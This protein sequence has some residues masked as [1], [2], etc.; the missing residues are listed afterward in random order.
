VPWMHY[1]G[2]ECLAEDDTIMPQ[3]SLNRVADYL[4]K[5]TSRHLSESMSDRELLER[6]VIHREE[7]A[8]AAIVGRH[9]PMVN[10]VCRRLLK[11]QA[12]ADDA[13][14]ATFLILLRKAGSIAKRE[15][16]ASWLHGVAHRVSNRAHKLNRREQHLVES[17]ESVPSSDDSLHQNVRDLQQWLDRAVLALPESYRSAFILCC[18]EGRSYAHAASL[19]G[20]AEG[21][22][23]SRVVRARERLR[24]SFD[25]SGFA[26]SGQ[27]LVLDLVR[28]TAQPGPES[29]QIMLRLCRDGTLANALNY[30]KAGMLAKGVLNSMFLAKAKFIGAIALIVLAGAGV[31]TQAYF[32]RGESSAGERMESKTNRPNADDLVNIPARR[33]GILQFLGMAIKPGEKVDESRQFTVEVNGKPIKYRRLRLGDLVERG[34]IIG[35]VDDALAVAAVKVKEAK[36][37]GADADLLASEKTRDESGERWKTAK[38]LRNTKVSAMSLED[39]RGAKL[40]YDRYVYETESKQAAVEIAKQELKQAQA[41]L[42]SYQIISGVRGI[43]HRIHKRAGEAVRSLETVVTLELVPGEE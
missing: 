17:A 32:S 23:S 1:R 28:G 37:R 3:K 41:T 19:L 25:R 38:Q 18:M 30:S 2:R 8:F 29:L 10:A 21:T 24:S 6:F 13:F 11:Q 15:S 5:L 42:D 31:T 12:D 40:T 20:C 26:C 4:C 34:E 16:L 27:L 9:G 39:V 33:E 7:A 36:V 35:R 22:V 14:Q 43:V